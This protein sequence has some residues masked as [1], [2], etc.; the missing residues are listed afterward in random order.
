MEEDD[1][2]PNSPESSDAKGD[3]GTSLRLYLKGRS[4]PRPPHQ[5]SKLGLLASSLASLDITRHHSGQTSSGQGNDPTII[6]I[7]LGIRSGSLSGKSLDL[8][9][10]R[11]ALFP[12]FSSLIFPNFLLSFPVIFAA[13][14]R[15]RKARLGRRNPSHRRLGAPLSRERRGRGP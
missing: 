11:G 6:S 1:F 3:L 12:Y 7:I 5:G 4:F 2:L 10:R 15:L 8:V 13:A 9:E 14:D